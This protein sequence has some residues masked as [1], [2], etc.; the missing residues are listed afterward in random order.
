MVFSA[1]QKFEFTFVVDEQ[2]HAGF[3]SLFK[4][5]NPLHIS[6]DFASEKKFSSKVMHGNILN[7]FLSWFVG[8]GLPSKD[9]VIQA[10]T[11]QFSKPVYLNDKVTLR[12]EIT[13]VHE[14]VKVVMFKFQ[15]TN[16]NN[17]RVAK[18][19]IQIGMI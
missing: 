16:N 14:S 12:A 6:D 3:I 18:G 17:E 4:D 15:F 9:V 8:E 1:G 13:E 5:K 2:L 11:I 10:Q 7:G 19:T